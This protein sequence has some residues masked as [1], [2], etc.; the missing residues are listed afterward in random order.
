MSFAGGNG[1]S[2]NPYLIETAD[3]LNEVRNGLSLYYKLISDIDL[4]VSPYNTGN[5]W[6]PIGSVSSPF[7]GEIDFDGFKVS[8]LYI[9]RG[10]TD[11]VGLF[12]AISGS[13]EKVKS[14]ALINVSI[15][16]RNYVGALAGT[17]NG[18]VF[19]FFT[20]G[21]VNGNE[22]VGGF[23]GFCGSGNSIEKC[24]SASIVDGS[25]YVGGFVGRINYG[26]ITNCFSSGDV[27]GNDNYIGGFVGVC[28]VYASIEK[29]LSFGIVDGGNSEKYVSPHP[30]AGNYVSVG[31]FCGS[32]WGD[33]TNSYWDK[34]TSGFDYSYGGNGYITSEL[35]TP[36]I[37]SGIFSTW[38]SSVWWEVNT[39][40]Y[41]KLFKTL[42]YN[43]GSNGSINGTS[44]QK[45]PYG[46][47]G[48]AVTAE[49]NTG[50]S[51][52]EWSD[53]VQTETRQDKFV[54]KDVDVTATFTINIYTLK[55]NP[56]ANATLT[57]TSPQSVEH[58][59]NGTQVQ[60]NPV[61]DYIFIKWSDGST[62]NPRTD[63]NVT[64]NITIFAIVSTGID[65]VDYVDVVLN[66]LTVLNDSVF[67]SFVPTLKNIYKTAK[68][69]LFNK[70]FLKKSLIFD[71]KL[72]TIYTENTNFEY[73]PETEKLIMFNNIINDGKN[74]DLRI[75]NTI[76]TSG[77]DPA[78]DEIFYSINT[79]DFYYNVYS[80]ISKNIT[81]LEYDSTDFKKMQV[82]ATKRLL[83]DGIDKKLRYI[84]L[85]AIFSELTIYALA[86]FPD[87]ELYTGLKHLTKERFD[88]FVSKGKLS[89]I[90]LSRNDFE[91][92]ELNIFNDRN[93]DIIIDVN[94]HIR[95]KPIVGKYFQF[96]F[97]FKFEPTEEKDGW[98]SENKVSLRKFSIGFEDLP[99]RQKRF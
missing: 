11:Y 23:I 97:V 51:I 31:G 37:G 92:K 63:L 93:C 65:Y 74:N 19:D 4:D 64:G 59:S 40:S 60:V 8:N 55:Y 54:L 90:E 14:G 83:D 49:P 27:S 45:I 42:T 21:T 80:P 15:S 46:D 71:S 98:A 72:R 6:E 44:P 17:L 50:Y 7:T 68:T 62:N 33:I 66:P 96:L 70:N 94:K 35:Q 30:D 28:D 29:C 95:M 38:S 76:D 16:G 61:D 13:G 48:A 9:S 78:I 69:S 73:D 47:N 99:A 56:G 85:S 3:Q 81:S 26:Y 43:A 57:G 22:Y 20:T 75:Y 41:P 32:I 39:S 58:G 89:K 86:D 67:I 18:Y 34:T 82:I 79:I 5:G 24:S 88:D 2:S 52:V 91:D 10:S 36:Q 12:G 87:D 25:K 53:G 84:K 1:T 77:S